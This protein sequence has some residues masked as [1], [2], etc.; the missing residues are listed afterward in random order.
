L[1]ATLK[2]RVG[3][4]TNLFG[5]P[6]KG[7]LAWEPVIGMLYVVPLVYTAPLALVGAWRRF[8]WHLFCDAGSIHA[9]ESRQRRAYIWFVLCMLVA[10]LG[11]AY[12]PATIY[13]ATMRYLSDFTNA[14][15]LLS[16][17]GLFGWF[18]V[19]TSLRIHR[20]LR[21]FVAVTMIAV[22]ASCGVLLGY[23]GYLPYFKNHNPALHNRIAPALSFCGR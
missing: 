12:I 3:P 16:V 6:P 23:Q 20:G 18:G 19:R 11:S 14:L 15:L 7:Y 1:F 10:A 21:V 5:G 22:T 4:I 17:L 8:G 2:N 9:D 13:F